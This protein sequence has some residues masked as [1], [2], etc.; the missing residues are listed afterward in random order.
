MNVNANYL[1]STHNT[2]YIMSRVNIYLYG[3]SCACALPRELLAL[4]VG[5]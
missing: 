4:P 5:V 1:I 2:L 3:E